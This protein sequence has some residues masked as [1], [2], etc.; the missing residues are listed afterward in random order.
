MQKNTYP[1][2]IGDDDQPLDDNKLVSEYS[3]QNGDHFRTAKAKHVRVK[4]GPR[5]VERR[6]QQ[7]TRRREDLEAVLAKMSPAEKAT[8]LKQ[9]AEDNASGDTEEGAIEV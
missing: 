4:T 1:R 2:L 5:P 3:I 6:R 9:S 8:F 7:A